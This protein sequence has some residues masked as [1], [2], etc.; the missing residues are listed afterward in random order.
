MADI[1]VMLFLGATTPTGTNLW[2]TEKIIR[3]L[4]SVGEITDEKRLA[5]YGRR[6]QL[7]CNT[8]FRA[9][10]PKIVKLE[11][12]K[13]YGVHLEQ[14]R[15]AGFFDRSYRD[16]VALDYFVK[17]TQRN[18]SRMNAIYRK[19]DDIREAGTWTR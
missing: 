16:F 11:Y 3:L 13:T 18:D 6:L 17:K 1:E 14:Y 5:L 19:V 7:L 4:S 2:A 15:L 10:M 12:G 8:G 9:Y